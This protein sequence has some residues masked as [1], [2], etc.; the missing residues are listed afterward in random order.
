M[1]FGLFDLQMFCGNMFSPTI[2]QTNKQ[3]NMG[4]AARFSCSFCTGI[5]IMVVLS[6][7][8]MLY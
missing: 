6:F 5:V 2:K 3:L 1:D 7:S 8:A 4:T